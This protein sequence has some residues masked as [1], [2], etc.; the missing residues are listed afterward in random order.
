MRGVDG[1]EPG[2]G[3]DVSFRVLFVCAANI[4]R[5]PTA[6]RVFIGRLPAGL[7]GLVS[8]ESVGVSAEPGLP[9]C[10]KAQDWVTA[11]KLEVGDMP[12]HRSRRLTAAK[13]TR[14]D[15]IL[16]ADTDVKSAVLR[17]DLGARARLFTL[18]E[19][20]TLATGVEGALAAA[21]LD[22][23]P[24][25]SE[26]QLQPLPSGV[27]EDRLHWLVEEMDAARGLVVASGRGAR[28]RGFDLPDPHGGK[29]SA[30]HRDMLGTLTDAVSSFTATMSTIIDT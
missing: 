15:L 16:A 22:G 8:A 27:G 29:G 28:A 4:C 6:A 21:S 11:H 1:D 10:E 14:A 23:P 18:L 19:A 9:W 13:M 17:T 5:S 24:D 25:P 20:S 12:E 3:G 7:V 2:E 26:L 30:T